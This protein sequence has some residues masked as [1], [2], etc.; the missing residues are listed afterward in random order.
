MVVSKSLAIPLQHGTNPN[1]VALQAA[2]HGLEQAKA[3]GD[4]RQVKQAK[5]ILEAEKAEAAKA[6]A[7]AERERAEAEAAEEEAAR[8]AA[9]D[10]FVPLRKTHS[11]I[12]WQEQNKKLI[13]L[14][15]H[16][17]FMDPKLQAL[18]IKENLDCLLNLDL[19]HDTMNNILQNIITPRIFLAPPTRKLC[20][21][22]HSPT[23]FPSCSRRY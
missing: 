13:E 17:E 9:E 1:F 5:A 20:L 14:K 23:Q 4:R 16:N 19:D 22:S 2:E 10:Y 7:S 12:L 21:G 3:S 8:E 6:Q 11:S 18:Y 15:K